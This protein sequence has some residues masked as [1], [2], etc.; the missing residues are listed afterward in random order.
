MLMA[1]AREVGAQPIAEGIE[2]EKEAGVCTMMGF[3][4]AQGYLY[5]KPVPLSEL[6]ELGSDTIEHPATEAL[7]KTEET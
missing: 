6:V 4:L 3:T 2:T 5:S 7:E 1:A